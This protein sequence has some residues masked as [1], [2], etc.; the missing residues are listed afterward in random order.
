MKI[1]ILTL[2]PEMFDIF[3]H[4]IIGRAR[5][6]KIV[7]IE[8]IN[9]RDFSLNKHKK[10]DDYPYGGGAGMVMTPQPLADS[11]KYCKKNNKGKVIF[12]GPRGKTFNQELAKE[13]AKEEELIFVCGHYEGI[14]ERVYKYIDLEIS[15]GDFILTGGEMAAIPIIDS[16]LRLKE[17]VLGKSESF[18][19]ESFSD[20]L[21]EYPQYT[22]PEIFEGEAVPEVLL[23]GHHE[24]IRKWRRLKSL[25][26]TKEKRPDLYNKVKLSKEDLK[27]LK[28][29]K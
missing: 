18:E 16:I 3:S 22:R 29:K 12:L 10:V 8:P 14:D 2:F 6:K 25:E 19:E 11:I 28:N 15:L 5:E 1:N 4:S 9:I 7:E 23:S 26:V 24:N 21:L 20:G 27:L 17:G 13:L